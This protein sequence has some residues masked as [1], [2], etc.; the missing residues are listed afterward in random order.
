M[1]GTQILLTLQPKEK[2]WAKLFIIFIYY[3]LP[4]SKKDV[5]WFAMKAQTQWNHTTKAKIQKT[6]QAKDSAPV[7]KLILLWVSW[8]LRQK[9]KC[10]GVLVF[11]IV[12]KGLNV[13]CVYLCFTNTFL[14]KSIPKTWIQHVRVNTGLK[15]W[16][17][18]WRKVRYWRLNSSLCLC[19]SKYTNGVP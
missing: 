2:A 10:N 3:G 13:H 17:R 5:Q 7:E 1:R 12:I 4:T 19:M 14:M 15:P 16:W 11:V 9:G 6:V 18:I 8:G